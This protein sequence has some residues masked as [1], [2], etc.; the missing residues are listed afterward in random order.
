M[1][2]KYH[3]NLDLHLVHD[4]E[5]YKGQI[6]NNGVKNPMVKESCCR[7]RAL[8]LQALYNFDDNIGEKP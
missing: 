6:K 8:L 4:I 3:I 5:I 2:K 7:E 1:L